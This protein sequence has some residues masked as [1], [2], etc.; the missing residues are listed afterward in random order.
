MCLPDT[1]KKDLAMLYHLDSR[2][3]QGITNRQALPIDKMSYIYLLYH[4]DTLNTKKS[5]FQSK[6]SETLSPK[7]PVHLM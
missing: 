4:V 3:K 1:P 6:E 5:P 2:Y 7:K